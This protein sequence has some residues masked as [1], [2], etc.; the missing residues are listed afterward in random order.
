MT[1]VDKEQKKPE[2]VK[3]LRG[4]KAYL[5]ALLD[6]SDRVPDHWTKHKGAFKCLL[7]KVWS[8]SINDYLVD[9]DQITRHAVVDLIAKTWEK[10]LVGIGNDALGL[11]HS[12]LKV[13]NVQRIEN[14]DVYKDYRSGIQSACV[15]G[16]KQDFKTITSFNNE[17]EIR[18]AI[19]NTT[20]LDA[21]RI[22]E[23]NEY[24]LFHGMKDN[25]KQIVT[26]GLDSRMSSNGL[27]GKGIY[28]AESSTK[29][30]QY[31]GE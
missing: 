8:S 11:K 13:I 29:A 16:I 5:Q 7:L 27:F 17:R 25:M 18:T 31:A 3:R 19:H 14:P 9:V 24:F 10:D 20:I 26:Q 1:Q 15:E 22:K 12:S 28:L 21:T 6:K 2:N 23:I 30:D 4:T